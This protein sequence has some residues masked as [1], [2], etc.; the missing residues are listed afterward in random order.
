MLAFV[1][2]NLSNSVRVFWQVAKISLPLLVV[3]KYLQDNFGFIDHVGYWLSPLMGLLN[4]PGEAGVIWATAIFLQIYPA[5]I[6]LI[7]LWDDLQLNV[8]QVSTLALLILVAHNL[9]IEGR[10]V[11]KAG[12]RIFTAIFFRIVFGLFFSA[13]FAWLY[14]LFDW[15]QQPA[16]LI[17]IKNGIPSQ[18]FE[19]AK[20]QAY[21]WF[22]IWLIILVL[23]SLID[24]MKITRFERVMIKILHPI[25]RIIGIGEKTITITIIG[26]TLGIA[27]GGGLL[28]NQSNDREIPKRDLICALIFLG[29]THSIVEDTLLMLL[30]GAD[31]SVVLFGRVFLTLLVMIFLARFIKNLSETQF[32]RW[33]LSSQLLDFDEK[34]QT[35]PRH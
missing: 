2:R 1:S 4:L 11:Q 33:F 23:V 13:F 5:I 24:F 30:I 12:F 6:L 22:E 10:I 26:M 7:S 9:V 8:A 15:F 28:I 32:R 18:W 16:N 20:Y 14:V 21:I 34:K 31:I 35:T 17:L 19:W 25:L 27:Y 29:L 3:I